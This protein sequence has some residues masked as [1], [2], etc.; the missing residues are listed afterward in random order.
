MR[1]RGLAAAAGQ[2]VVLGRPQ[3]VVAVAACGPGHCVLLCASGRVELVRVDVGGLHLPW[4]ARLSA[5]VVA[6]A[7]HGTV[8]ALATVRVADDAYAATLDP[9]GTLSV[10]LL[11]DEPVT[12]VTR[13]WDDRGT[14]DGPPLLAMAAAG[15]HLLVAAA[16]GRRIWTAELA[17]PLAADA[18]ARAVSR[19]HHPDSVTA[20]AVVTPADGPPLV[21]VGDAGGH[22]T[23]VAPGATSVPP[24]RSAGA[25][26]PVLALAADPSP[27]HECLLAVLQ[28]DGAGVIWR[29]VPDAD[30]A[31]H[32]ALPAVPAGA[33]ALSLHAGGGDRRLLAGAG[34]EDVRV[35][36][37]GGDGQVTVQVEGVRSLALLR[38]GGGDAVAALA[39]GGTELLLRELDGTGRWLDPDGDGPGPARRGS[40]VVVRASADQPFTGDG[41]DHLEFGRYAD[42]LALLLENE[43]TGTPVTVAIDGPW[44]S[45]KTS[46]GRMVR[47][48]LAREE[49]LASSRHLR[50]IAPPPIT[51]W[52][53]AWMNDG[54]ERLSAALASSITKTLDGAR[55]WWQRLLRPLDSRLLD[56]AS[57]RRRRLGVLLAWPLMVAVAAAVVLTL[58][59]AGPAW[60]GALVDVDATGPSLVVVG[61]ASVTVGLLRA[62][63][64]ALARA[65]ATVAQFVRDPVTLTDT[66][67]VARVRAELGEFISAA[68]AARPRPAGPD[69][70]RLRRWWERRLDMIARR[71]VLA[72]TVGRLLALRPA[73]RFVLFVDNLDRC[74]PQRAV[75]ACETLNQLVDHPD[76]ATVLMV[77]LHALAVAAEIT[78]SDV[79]QRAFPEGKG[80]GWGRVFLE[81]LVQFDF[82][83]PAPSPEHLR[84]VFRANTGAGP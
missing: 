40:G 27:S 14:A 46:L 45:G 11:Q 62:V 83:L 84:A 17:L 44:G 54:G 7:D 21:A 65:G 37:L 41:E 73:R 29:V 18:V 67:S 66:G 72:A 80:E 39:T 63:Q 68:T 9:A 38:P 13:P 30:T 74:R 35:W 64:V 23:L 25:A 58:V 1:T 42:A 2:A 3:P 82:T 5:A 75:D 26:G 49:P 79:A 71:R 16:H 15:D 51:C 55:P 31:V 19:R 43:H 61:G 34:P 69:A 56:P 12:V 53:D 36:E 76:V 52:F 33:S 57:R 22:S 20:L 6:A 4:T 8:G 24:W 10:S 77:D 60:L 48:R 78:F 32:A 70:G 28:G 81:K 50:S 59:P 47:R